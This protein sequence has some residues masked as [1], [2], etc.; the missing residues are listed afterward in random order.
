M[1]VEKSLSALAE[2]RE[3]LKQ[4][5]GEEDMAMAR[6]GSMFQPENFTWGPKWPLKTFLGANFLEMGPI[7][8]NW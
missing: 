3:A 5:E 4:G 2:E 1:I 7:D 6:R 8:N